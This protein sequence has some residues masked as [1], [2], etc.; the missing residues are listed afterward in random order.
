MVGTLNAPRE[1][2]FGTEG[3]CDR[4][5]KRTRGKKE[6][7]C[8]CPPILF[9]DNLQGYVQPSHS[10]LLNDASKKLGN[11]TPISADIEDYAWASGWRPLFVPNALAL[12]TCHF[13]HILTVSASFCLVQIL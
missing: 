6:R 2:R 7:L 13:S 9:L 1:H 10:C 8:N 3:G 12:Q 5:P 4:I 11:Y